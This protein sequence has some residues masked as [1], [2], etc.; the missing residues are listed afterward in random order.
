[1]GSMIYLRCGAVEIDWGKNGGFFDH[2][3]L[4]QSPD[5]KTAGYRYVADDGAG[6]EYVE[7]RPAL[8]RPLR[9]VVPRLRLL[10][11]TAEAAAKDWI[12]GAAQAAYLPDGKSLP[13]PA[14]VLTVF[15]GIRLEHLKCKDLLYSNLTVDPDGLPSEDLRTRIDAALEFVGPWELLALLGH[16][17]DNGDEL[18]VWEYADVLEGEWMEDAWLR[19]ALP[20]AKQFLIVGEGTSDTKIMAAAFSELRPDVA[21]FFYFVDMEAGYPFTG[22]GNVFRFCQGLV[23]M[24]LLNTVLFVL[25]NDAEGAATCAKI[26]ELGL[27]PNMAAMV[28][29]KVPEFEAFATLGPSGNQ[30]EDI[31]G[32]AVSIECFLD[33]SYGESRTPKV[34]WTGYHEPSQTH[35]GYHHS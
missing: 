6:E 14:E 21:D 29:P 5:F 24:R 27:P 16:N 26:Q 1:M 8:V 2:R 30:V 22:T 18:V 23:S 10:G 13:T 3:P 35:Q 20:T 11:V 7:D 19:A 33:L 9:L 12:D 28:L 34:R 17:P 32:R 31:N 25:D 4:F 15:S